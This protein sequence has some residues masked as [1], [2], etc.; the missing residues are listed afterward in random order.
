MG[1]MLH[2]GLFRKANLE[3]LLETNGIDREGSRR[4]DFIFYHPKIDAIAIE[5]DGGEHEANE[6]VDLERD[7]SLRSVGIDV[8]RIKNDEVDSGSGPNLDEL[9]KR[10][11]GVFSEDS[12]LEGSS[13]DLAEAFI[14]CTLGSKIQYGVVKGIEYGWL[15]ANSDWEISIKGANDVAFSAVVDLIQLLQG[16]D[17]IY[18]TSITP[19]AFDVVVGEKENHIHSMEV[20]SKKEERLQ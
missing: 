19:D 12:K 10:I 17:E 3:R 2:I 11:Q 9:K 13:L 20:R 16:L 18:G 15:E 6:A 7:N 8:I 1:K 4:V 5:I 14:D